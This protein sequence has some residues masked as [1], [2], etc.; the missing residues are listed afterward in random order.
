MTKRTAKKMSLKRFTALVESYGAR[1]D[2][3]PSAEREQ[4]IALLRVDG[5]AKSIAALAAGLDANLDTLA[6]PAP[7]N[8]A[9]ITRL[10]TI[11]HASAGNTATAQV[12]GT[13]G[14]YVRGLFG[15]R[16]MLPQ[17]L[18]LAA[19]GLIGVWLGFSAQ[20]TPQQ[21]ITLNAAKLVLTASDLQDDLQTVE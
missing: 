8:D 14:G 7:A 21:D 18:S 19:A 12:P 9:F 4:A 1:P 16:A 2:C 5:Q 20:A 13:F 11:P 3:W 10:G 15:T 17:G 6:A